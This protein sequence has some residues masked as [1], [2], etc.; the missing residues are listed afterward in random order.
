LLI[1]QLS[2]DAKGL[3]AR[4][5]RGLVTGD[6]ERW[7]GVECSGDRGWRRRRCAGRRGGDGDR[8]AV[9]LRRRV[10]GTQQRGLKQNKGDGGN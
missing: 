8:W 6:C 1:D 7:I 5:M 9:V 10:L 2:L 4:G 3:L